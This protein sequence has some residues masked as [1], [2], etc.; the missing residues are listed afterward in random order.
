MYSKN[1]FSNEVYI[2]EEIIEEELQKS[3]ASLGSIFDLLIELDENY[4][5]GASLETQQMTIMSRDQKYSSALDNR[6]LD[7]FMGTGN[8]QFPTMSLV[9]VPAEGQARWTLI[10]NALDT[11]ANNHE[12]AIRLLNEVARKWETLSQTQRDQYLQALRTD[13]YQ[14]MDPRKISRIPTQRKPTD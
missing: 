10:K 5:G 14:Y 2:P 12:Q 3:V 9:S 6:T 1:S 8:H 7:I 4:S 11:N 13:R